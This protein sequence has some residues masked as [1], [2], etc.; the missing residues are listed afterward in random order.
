[1]GSSQDLIF[2]LNELLLC[3]VQH[4]FDLCFNL[5]KLL[6]DFAQCSWFPV[7][8]EGTKTTLNAS[9]FVNLLSTCGHV[10]VEGSEPLV[11]IEN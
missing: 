7:F 4:E 9:L 3:V 5:A 11:E 2:F 1:M 10:L 6:L 8:F